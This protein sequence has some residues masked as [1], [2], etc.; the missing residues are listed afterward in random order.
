MDFTLP[1]E[2][3]QG[4]RGHLALSATG[5]ERT[6]DK[7]PGGGIHVAVANRNDGI[8]ARAT[9]D[10]L[11]SVL[12][13]ALVN[14]YLEGKGSGPENGLASHSESLQSS[15]DGHNRKSRKIKFQ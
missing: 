11:C 1:S 15:R 2:E 14:I 9:R 6:S 3:S 13:P 8:T 5:C 7:G 10:W 12:V 4:Q